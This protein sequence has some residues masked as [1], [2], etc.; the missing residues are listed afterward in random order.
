MPIYSYGGSIKD[1]P[2]VNELNAV[3]KVI[4]NGRKNVSQTNITN[5]LLA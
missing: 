3:N 2:A 5:F 4:K 1:K